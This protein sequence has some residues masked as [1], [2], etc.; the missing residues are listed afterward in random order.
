MFT[1]ASRIAVLLHGGLQGRQG[2][3]G[4]ALIRYRPEQIAVVIDQDCPGASFRELTGI[5]CDVPVVAHV[6]D[7]LAY[8]PDWLAIGIAPSGGVLPEDWAVEV[9]E[10][11][12][13]GLSIANGLHTKMAEIPALQAKCQRDGQ[14]IWDMRQEPVGLKVGTG[15][16]RQLRAKRV[17]A[18]GTDMSVGKMS[19]CL[20]LHR[21]AVAQ[22]VKAQFLGTGQAGIMIA[23]AGVPLD[24]VRVDFASG[25]IEQLVMG[26]GDDYEVLF[27]EGQGSVF[28]PASTATLPLMRGSQPT[29]L[30]LVHR[31]GQTAIRN[32]P[33]VPIPSLS[34]VIAVYESLAHAGGSFTP[35]K[36][37]G[38]ALNTGHLDEDEAIK[39]IEAV[40]SETGLPCTDVVRYGG[41]GLL[42]KI[43]GD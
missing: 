36:V 32:F 24:A 2:K 8:Q 25:A 38:I 17:L 22:G 26:A 14:V 19:A 43:V 35:A 41:Q 37:V 33:D 12:A 21:S 40:R 7:A 6:A 5:P 34:Q 10:A 9:E 23:G 18:V 28:H 20:E 16:A 1:T 3:T 11:V 42:A 15:T 39:A 29:H 30:I 27:V 4:L 13:A 31:A